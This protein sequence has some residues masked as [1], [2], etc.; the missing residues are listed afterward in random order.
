[1]NESDFLLSEVKRMQRFYKPDDLANAIVAFV[2]ER[3]YPKVTVEA[4]TPAV[5]ET[6]LP[7]INLEKIKE[8]VLPFYNLSWEQVTA[9][10]RKTE[11]VQT[12]RKIM[13]LLRTRAGMS[14]TSIGKIF[15]MDHSSVIHSRDKLIGLMGTDWQVRREIEFLNSQL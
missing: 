8:V 3:Y 15:K 10:N 9:R 13:Y 1:M 5:L 11:V 4:P 7:P 2:D 6:P 12:R 14:L